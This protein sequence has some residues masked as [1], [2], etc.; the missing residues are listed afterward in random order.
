MLV[1][2]YETSSLLQFQ[3]KSLV[4]RFITDNSQLYQWSLFLQ[5]YWKKTLIRR[6]VIYLKPD[7][8]LV[9]VISNLDQGHKKMEL[10][11][12]LPLFEEMPYFY[13]YKES[14]DEEKEQSSVD[15]KVCLV[16]L[17]YWNYLLWLGSFLWTA[18]CTEGIE[19]YWPYDITIWARMQLYCKQQCC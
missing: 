3:A 10:V 12:K 6:F 13:K 17:C 14:I 4:I 18:A 16:Q 2:K 11:I 7:C 15:M 8:D 5:I 1:S 19:S 9:T